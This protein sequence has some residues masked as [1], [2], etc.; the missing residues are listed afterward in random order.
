MND[1]PL[2]K[3]RLK[4]AGIDESFL[5][6]FVKHDLGTVLSSQDLFSTWIERKSRL[7]NSFDSTNFVFPNKQGMDDRVYFL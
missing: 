2:S 7:W 4:M 5:L 1:F 6:L 3:A